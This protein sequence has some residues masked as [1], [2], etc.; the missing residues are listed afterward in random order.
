MT[1]AQDGQLSFERDIK[2][3]FREKDRDSMRRRFDLFAYADVA[4]NADAIVGAVR[5]GKM[6]C[7]GTWSADKVD[8]LQAWI[9][10]GK[11]A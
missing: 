3:M 4:Q 10:A 11:P 6:P 1:T 5:S 8:K 7:D 2:P 9:D